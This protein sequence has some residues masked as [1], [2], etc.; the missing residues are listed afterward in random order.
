MAYRVF[1][2]PAESTSTIHPKP[3]AGGQEFRRI[4]DALTWARALG[5]DMRA[6][7]IIDER[8]PAKVTVRSAEEAART[9]P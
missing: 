1:A 2:A 9:T 4:R 7:L 8:T 3:A 5:R 6:V